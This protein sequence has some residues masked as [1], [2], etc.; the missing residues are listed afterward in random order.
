MEHLS[1]IWIYLLGEG[2]DVWRPVQAVH[3]NGDVYR[4][5][6]L[7]PDPEQETWEFNSKELV[8]CKKCKLDGNS[9]L[10]AYEHA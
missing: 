4:I 7:N 8:R 3:V 10:V 2:T 5:V 1:E 6:S 9:C